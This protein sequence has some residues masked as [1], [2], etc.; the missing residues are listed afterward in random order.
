MLTICLPIFK[1][2]WLV[3]SVVFG[4][5]VVCLLFVLTVLSAVFLHLFVPFLDALLVMICV[6]ADSHLR[7]KWDCPVFFSVC[8]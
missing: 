1:K 3:V 7:L 8:L 2:G 6:S 4:I 5:H